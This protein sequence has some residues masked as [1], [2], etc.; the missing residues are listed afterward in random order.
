MANA[1]REHVKKTMA[2]MKSKARGTVVMLKDVLKVAGKTY[3]KPS[4]SGAAAHGKTHKKKRS[5][6]KSTKKR[7][8]KSAKKH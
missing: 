1:W 7:G 4:H 6:K 2:E 5:T 8:G 3:K